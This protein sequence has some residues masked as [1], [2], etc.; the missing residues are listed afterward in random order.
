MDAF[1]V[2]GGYDLSR[3]G[4]LKAIGR[5]DNNN[6]WSRAGNLVTARMGHGAVFIDGFFLVVGG[7][8]DNFQTEKCELH[9]GTVSCTSQAPLLSGYERYPELFLI[10]ETFCQI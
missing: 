1:Y 10:S 4:N 3:Q 7:Y 5:L 8:N 2:L 9:Q 6:S